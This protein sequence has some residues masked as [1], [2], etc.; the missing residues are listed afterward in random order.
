MERTSVNVGD[1]ASVGYEAKTQTLEIEFGSGDIYQ[2]H[3]VPF[4]IY[5]GLMNAASHEDYFQGSI[6][7]S[8]SSTLVEEPSG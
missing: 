2:Y 1:L 3:S 4:A 5:G 7:N 8:Y 6:K